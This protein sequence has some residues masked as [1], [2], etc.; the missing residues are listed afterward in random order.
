MLHWRRREHREALILSSFTTVCLTGLLVYWLI[1]QL[2]LLNRR[3]LW[4]LVGSQTLAKP[5]CG[6]SISG[7]VCRCR[8]AAGNVSGFD[9]ARFAGIVHRSLAER[10]LAAPLYGLHRDE[11]DEHHPVAGA[12]SSLHLR[13]DRYRRQ[14]QG[15]RGTEVRSSGRTHLPQIALSCTYW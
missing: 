2:L 15:P 10:V 4:S 1:S 12:D 3:L 5:Y 7:C 14:Q 6:C 13:L 8:E 9:R 11:D